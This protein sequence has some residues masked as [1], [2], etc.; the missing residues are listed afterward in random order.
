MPESQAEKEALREAKAEALREAASALDSGE[1]RSV[2][3]KHSDWLRERAD[4]I[5]RPG[6]HA[7]TEPADPLQVADDAASPSF[8]PG[9]DRDE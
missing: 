4:L 1:E 5:N 9:G 8:R 7:A 6:T 3:G 2:C